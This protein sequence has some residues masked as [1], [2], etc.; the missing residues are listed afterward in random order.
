MH[1]IPA[2]KQN[3]TKKLLS[4]ASDPMTYQR[5]YITKKYSEK[6]NLTVQACQDKNSL[7]DKCGY[8]GSIRDMA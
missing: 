4:L 8:T 7:Y 1:L 6:E 5:T 3:K 2:P